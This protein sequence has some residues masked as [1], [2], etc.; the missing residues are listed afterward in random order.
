MDNNKKRTLREIKGNPE[1]FSKLSK[2]VTEEYASSELRFTVTYFSEKYNVNKNCI[3]KMIEYAIEEN[4]VEDKIVTKAKAKA[5]KNQQ[6][7]CESA[8][9][10]TEA[11]YARLYTN[12]CKKIAEKM[13]EKNVEEIAKF[14]AENKDIPKNEVAVAFE[15]SPRTLDF[16]LSRAIEKNIIDDDTVDLIEKR[17]IQKSNPLN[18]IERA[19]AIKA[20]F[21]S[22]RK[23][24]EECKNTPSK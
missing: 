7:H 24:R 6:L 12:R 21:A 23:K 10:S 8:G 13:P 22:A 4:L 14:F 16:L 20:Y 11:K 19:T 15:L 2:K 3:N 9:S 18:E 5:I 1:E 17:T